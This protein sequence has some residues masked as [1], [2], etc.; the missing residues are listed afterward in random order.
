MAGNVWEW[1]WDWYAGHAPA[2]RVIR[3]GDC[4]SDAQN[5]CAA[6]TQRAARPNYRGGDEGFAVGLR[7]I[8]SLAPGALPDGS[9]GVNLQPAGAIAAGAGWRVDDGE[10]QAAG[11][12]VAAS[13]GP[14]TVSFRPVEGWTTP[15]AQAVDVTPSQKKTLTGTYVRLPD[16]PPSAIL[17][18]G[19]PTAMVGVVYEGLVEADANATRP[20]TFSAK[21]LPAGLKLNSRTGAIT[22]TP[23]KAGVFTVT[24]GA[25]NKAGSIARQVRMTVLPLPAWAQGT[26]SGWAVMTIND[27]TAE[28]DREYPGTVTLSVSATGKITGKLVCGGTSYSLGQAAYRTAEP[29]DFDDLVLVGS[30]KVGKQV[31]GLEGAVGVA[32]T[33]VGGITMTVSWIDAWGGDEDVPPSCEFTAYRNPWK[34]LGTAAVLGRYAGYYTAVLP[35]DDDVGSGFLAFTVDTK[36]AVKIAGKLADGTAVSA[37]SALVC[38]DEGTVRTLISAAPSAYKGGAFLGWVEF[39]APGKGDGVMLQA[40]DG[41]LW[42]HSRNPQATEE[43]GEGFEREVG[44]YGGWYSKVIDLKAY[45]ENGLTVGGVGALPELLISTKYTDFDPDSEKERPPKIS[46]T[47]MGYAE[48]AAG[49]PEGLTLAVTLSKGIGTGLAAPKP[50]KPQRWAEDGEVGYEYGDTNEDG[51]DNAS[52]LTLSFTRATGLF[53]GSFTLWYDY[54]SAEDWTREDGGVKQAHVSKKVS[55]EGILT[56]NRDEGDAEGRGFFLWGDQSEYDTGKV[57]RDGEPIMKA[58]KFN[59][60]YDFWIDSL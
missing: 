36:G 4:N 40:R 21:G 60:S 38:D 12:T 42:W 41:A 1:C 35:S 15:P 6:A 30:V 10:W 50:D 8:T 48:P 24:F 22:G 52:A 56:P 18:D 13:A 3:S 39:L 33:E 28:L 43:Y 20:V 27:P 46:W 19:L 58:Y 5:G 32:E 16:E 17:T 59:R 7:P 34:D 29:G 44:L 45:Y 9:L 25:K 11:A 53:K 14:H 55:F 2:F 57:N 51:E 54:I 49:G 26:F 23:T 47:E 37:S 31:L